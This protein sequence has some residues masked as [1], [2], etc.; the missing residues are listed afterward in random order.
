MKKIKKVDSDLFDKLNIALTK[1]KNELN[2]N[3]DTYYIYIKFDS[4]KNLNE[5]LMVSND[6][7]SAT[8]MGF[9]LINSCTLEVN[10][11]EIRKYKI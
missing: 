5:G 3:E 11:F 1:M 2:I 10:E 7:R 4:L 9:E 6:F 8:F